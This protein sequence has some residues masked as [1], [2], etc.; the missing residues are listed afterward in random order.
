MIRRNFISSAIA[1]LCAPFVTS[2]KQEEPKP[3]QWTKLGF[4]YD[5]RTKLNSIYVNERLIEMTPH[6]PR[7]YWLANEE[8]R[9]YGEENG[10]FLKD[11]D[12]ARYVLPGRN[13]YEAIEARG[14]NFR[15]VKR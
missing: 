5:P 6:P 2:C 13:G 9:I 15:M 7:V 14:R 1:L 3:E 4:V 8:L 12:W 10:Y 11:F